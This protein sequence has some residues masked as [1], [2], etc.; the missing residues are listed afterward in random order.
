VEL[1]QV[2]AVYFDEQH[3]LNRDIL[4]FMTSLHSFSRVIRK[5]NDA[6][7]CKSLINM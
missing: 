6:S 3:E 2:N 5:S 4:F 1:N 7:C